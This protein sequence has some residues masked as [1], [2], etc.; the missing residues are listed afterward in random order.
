MTVEEIKRV[1]ATRNELIELAQER[2]AGQMKTI[3]DAFGRD[4]D[5]Y[6]T[7]GGSITELA[8]ELG[9]HRLTL[10]RLMRGAKT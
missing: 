7:A 5:A 8:D 3:N 4:L 2:H 1:Y 6:R 10:H 9:V